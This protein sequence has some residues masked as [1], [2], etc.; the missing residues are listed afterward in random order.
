MVERQRLDLN[1]LRETLGTAMPAGENVFHML[2]I[3]AGAERRPPVAAGIPPALP[4]PACGKRPGRKAVDQA[5]ATEALQLVKA[6][7]SPTVAARKVGLGRSTVYR[8][9]RRAGVL[10]RSSRAAARSGSGGLGHVGLTP[11]PTGKSDLSG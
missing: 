8:E 10:P 4:L 11:Q 3:L 7:L 5:K 9:A 6:G 2:R 1:T